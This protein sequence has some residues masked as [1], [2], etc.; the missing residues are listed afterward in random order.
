MKT[1]INIK[2]DKEIKKNAQKVA[3]DLG[4]SLSAVINAYLRQFVR[5]KEVYFG[6]IPHM[7]PELEK[8]LGKVEVDIM[9]EKNISSAFSAE[10]ELKDYLASL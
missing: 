5:N 4:F 2:T 6:L 10:R 9:K 7:S 8:L 1:V 3:E